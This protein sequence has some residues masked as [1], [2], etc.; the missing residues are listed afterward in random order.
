M[1]TAHGH[2]LNTMFG[3]CPIE[4]H[5]VWLHLVLAGVAAY[6]GFLAPTY[7]PGAMTTDTT[8]SAGTSRTV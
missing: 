6:F 4:G 8:N 2:Q 1:R 3:L 7:Q 5:D